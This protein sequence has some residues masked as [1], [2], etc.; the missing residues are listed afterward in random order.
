MERFMEDP[1]ILRVPAAS[2][3]KQAV[4]LVDAALRQAVAD[5]RNALLAEGLGLAFVPP[6]IAA[7]HAM[8]RRWADAG[9]GR[10]RLALVV[11]EVMRD[12]ERFAMV[13]ARNFGLFAAAFSNE[14][15]ARAWLDE[16]DPL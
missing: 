12:P 16:P 6:D 2:T 7:R 11:P 14:A 15:D 9:Q 4:D 5:G 8:V 1:A 3:F 10:V 13:A